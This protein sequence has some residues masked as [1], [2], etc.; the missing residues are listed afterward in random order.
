[1][2]YR[3]ANCGFM[4]FSFIKTISNQ[5][6]IVNVFPKYSHYLT[7]KLCLWHCGIRS[8]LPMKPMY[9]L[10][11]QNSNKKTKQNGFHPSP[12][13]DGY[14]TFFQSHLIRLSSHL[15]L[16]QV[17]LSSH[18]KGFHV[19]SPCPSCKCRAKASPEFVLVCFPIK[20]DESRF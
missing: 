9:I 12:S 4:N 15:I 8:F 16:F 18:P 2:S 10:E 1:M 19:F 3:S 13:A 11:S 17:V 5:A 14:Y 6:C 7:K 20:G